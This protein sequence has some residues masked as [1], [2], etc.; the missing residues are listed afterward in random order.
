MPEIRL[1]GVGDAVQIAAIY[2]AVVLES[3]ASFELEPPGPEEMASRI[4]KVT[5]T[6]PWVVMTDDEQVLGYAYATTHRDRSA[7]RFVA[8]TTIYMG[9]GHRGLGLG[10]TLY[11]ALLELTTLWGYSS[12][13]AGIT[14]PNPS[15]EALHATVGFEK[16]GVFPRAGFKQDRWHDVSWWSRSLN[17]ADHPNEPGTPS[18]VVLNRALSNLG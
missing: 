13:Y 1:V 10:K 15:S 8:E 17:P 7:Y 16:V 11:R 4:A 18:P 12:A 5:A 6:H 3:V 9:P 2:D 14:V